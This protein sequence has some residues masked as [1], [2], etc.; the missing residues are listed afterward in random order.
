MITKE[1]DEMTGT[2]L[3]LKYERETNRRPS[4]FFDY[5]L[6]KGTGTTRSV[7]KSSPFSLAK[8]TSLDI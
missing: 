2:L 3:M 1:R 7:T 5:N 4:S 6:E 8:V